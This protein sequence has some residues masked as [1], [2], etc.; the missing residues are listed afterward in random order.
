MSIA[1][2]IPTW[3]H[4]E[5]DP[6]LR[7][8][9][10]GTTW[11]EQIAVTF[12]G[13][14]R[15][16]AA[17]G[18]SVER[19][20]T[21]ALDCFSHAESWAPA[22]AQEIAAVADGAGLELWQL[23]ALNA[24]TELLAVARAARGECSTFAVAPPA[25][26]PPRTLQ[27]W[28]WYDHLR[29]GAVTVELQPRPGRT[30]R[31]FTEF[32]VVGKIGVND[33]GFGL[34]FNILAH[35]AD[36]R[37]EAGVPVHV[38]ARRLLDEAASVD[39]AEALVRDVPLSASTVLTCVDFDGARGRVRMLELS[40]AGVAAITPA[41][42]DEGVL[43]HTNHFLD[44]GL[45]AG[46]RMARI[47]TSTGPRLE[48]LRE[49][50]LALVGAASAEERAAAM[51]DHG[52]PGLCCHPAADAPF[53]ERWETLATISLDIAQARLRLHAGGPCADAEWQTV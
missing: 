43:L 11:R 49:R 6:R 39:E 30:V 17:A 32:G 29:D 25:G 42:R 23:A 50:A 24:R 2:T 26:G 7:G 53:D 9:A 40:P 21:V 38:V 52:G 33:A 22:L 19:Q 31:L 35:T 46:E 47:D 48:E 10:F 37:E 1:T 3:R 45:A 13:Y 4:V 8:L 51:L 20:R 41:T 15:L 14:A 27:T 28:D 16:F 18:L 44:P 12:D 5:H 34:H 36:G